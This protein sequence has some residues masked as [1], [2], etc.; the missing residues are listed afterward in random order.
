MAVKVFKFGGAS[1]RDAAGIK[2]VTGIVKRQ[3]N[4]G[5]RLACV[6]SATGKTTNALEDVVRAAWE[7]R[8][9]LP[10]LDAV[11]SHHKEIAKALLPGF[12]DIPAILDE[13]GAKAAKQI[14]TAASLPHD[15][16]YDQVVSEGERMATALVSAYWTSENI[17]HKLA[18]AR[19]LIRTN[20]SWREGEVNRAA[21]KIAVQSEWKRLEESS[22]GSILLTQGFI[23]GGPGGESVTLGREGSDYT[24]AL[25]GAALGAESVTIWKDVAGVFNADPKLFPDAVMFTR[26]SYDDALELACYGA[27]II[28]PKTLSPLKE[29]AIPLL[30]KSFEN[31]DAPGT[32]IDSKP[33]LALVPALI[34]KPRQ[35]LWT[36]RAHN[37]H[38]IQT[39]HLSEIFLTASRH[40]LK[41]NALQHS[42][43][44]VSLCLEE[45]ISRLQP[46]QYELEKSFHIEATPSV[47]LITMLNY[48]PALMEAILGSRKPLL[49]Q[50][51][52]KVA[53]VAVDAANTDMLHTLQQVQKT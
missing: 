50:R 39:P 15:A 38:F 9:P 22:E 27:T 18:D 30:V 36:L 42:A 34:L 5:D 21:T 45:D 43:L 6:V 13:I 40:R 4:K 26:L 1:V 46:A 20:L 47:S 33:T 35:V 29:A 10:L 25:L 41:I 52:L 7:K 53:R 11:I 12:P 28:H 23:G 48:S 44:E 16:L 32:R 8:D 19:T 17:P 49:E 31:P 3:L 24:A 37:G 14:R 2:N 51:S